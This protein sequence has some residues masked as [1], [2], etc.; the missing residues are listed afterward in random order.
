MKRLLIAA[1]FALV[2]ANA[3]SAPAFAMAETAWCEIDP[4]LVVDGRHSDVHLLFPAAYQSSLTGP[5][6]FVFHVAAGSKAHVTYPNGQI[7]MH[8]VLLY[9]GASDASVVTVDAWVS[10]TAVFPTKTVVLRKFGTTIERL[11]TSEA[12]TTITYTLTR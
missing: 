4:K 1:L 10:A 6:E 9:D 3:S 11:G 8:V 12:R 7:P 5:V 2:L